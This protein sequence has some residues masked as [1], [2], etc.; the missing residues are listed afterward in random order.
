MLNY[1]VKEFFYDSSF[2]DYPSTLNR[3]IFTWDDFQR[4]GRSIRILPTPPRNVANHYF[5]VY[6]A[7]TAK[8]IAL[9]GS[10]M[11]KKMAEELEYPIITGIQ[12]VDLFRNLDVDLSIKKTEECDYIISL[13]KSA[14]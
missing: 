14:L 5:S 2:L 11:L 6:D 10:E 7:E 3:K 12:N 4:L 9:R 8:N 1:T 13:T